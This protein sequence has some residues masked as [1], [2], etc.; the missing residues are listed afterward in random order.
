MSEK[1]PRRVERFAL[2]NEEI[3]FYVPSHISAADLHIIQKSTYII[4]CFLCICF[5]RKKKGS[6]AEAK[7]KKEGLRIPK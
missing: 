7:I 3:F 6:D 5:G 1:R 2:I 4:F